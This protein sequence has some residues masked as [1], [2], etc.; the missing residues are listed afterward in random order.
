[1]TDT[2][3]H[4]DRMTPVRQSMSQ[5]QIVALIIIGA[6]VWFLAAM[7][8]RLLGPNGIFEGV[9]RVILYA[10]IVPG[11]VPFVIL[12]Q[13]LVRLHRSQIATGYTI[14]TTAAMLLDGIAL[15][16]FPAL[17][18]GNAEMVAGSGAAIL[19]GAGVGLVLAFWWNRAER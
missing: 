17:Y 18:G 19:W 5:T 10:L 16:W 1:M 11:T 9:N 13:R 3:S 15:A 6:A 4:F 8:L 7:F 2:A 12:T 14:A